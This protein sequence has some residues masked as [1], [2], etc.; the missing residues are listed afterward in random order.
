MQLQ[1]L[2][3]DPE[4]Q[5][6]LTPLTEDEHRRLKTDIEANGI[7]HPIVVWKD[8]QTIL[9]GHNRH[10]IAKELGID[11]VLV[12]EVELESRDD[13]IRFIVECQLS[14]RNATPQL[15]TYLLGRLYL[16]QKQSRGGNRRKSNGQNAHLNKTTAT[17]IADR[18]SVDEATV[19][20]AA[21]YATAIDRVAKIGGQDAKNAILSGRVK[22]THAD[23]IR[24]SELHDAEL[25]DVAAKI[26]DPKVSSLKDVLPRHASDAPER[27]EQQPESAKG[28][29]GEKAGHQADSRPRADASVSPGGDRNTAEQRRDS[30]PADQTDPALSTSSEADVE[31]DTGV[32]ICEQPQREAAVPRSDECD[33]DMK[34]MFGHALSQCADDTAKLFL[35]QGITHEFVDHVVK[36][37]SDGFRQEVV[38]TLKKLASKI[39][40]HDG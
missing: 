2:K 23:V 11:D 17:A 20:R 27:V 19:R 8:R 25:K 37:G 35:W 32:A 24:L 34:A 31:P 16:T 9:D 22:S 13:A 40:S 30:V 7:S 26:V 14:R 39:K 10:R 33:H 18:E 21:K 6:F 5:D 3:V 12:R 15:R 36:H 29:N 1:D 4:F 38:R 28:E